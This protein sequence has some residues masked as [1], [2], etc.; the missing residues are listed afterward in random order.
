MKNILVHVYEG[1]SASSRK[2]LNKDTL[3]NT[4]KGVVEKNATYAYSV[5]IDKFKKVDVYKARGI[6]YNVIQT[7]SVGFFKNW[8]AIHRMKKAIKTLVTIPSEW[9]ILLIGKSAGG[10]KTIKLQKTYKYFQKFNKIA[11]VTIDAHFKVLIGD[12]IKL[13]KKCKKKWSNNLCRFFNVFQRNKWPKGSSFPLANMNKQLTDKKYDHWNITSSKYAKD[14][15]QA[16]I[17]FVKK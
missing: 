12:K 7:N 14:A 1:Y 4:V 13:P 5:D 17:D 3:R 6:R 16:G 11:C 15:I 8:I 10:A 9:E 2:V